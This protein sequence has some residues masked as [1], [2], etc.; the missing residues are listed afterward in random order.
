MESRFDG[1]LYNEGQHIVNLVPDHRTAI[2]SASQASHPTAEMQWF[3]PNLGHAIDILIAPIESRK[4]E[5]FCFTRGHSS[6]SSTVLASHYGFGNSSIPAG[7]IWFRAVGTDRSN[8]AS[9]AE[10]P[11]QSQLS[12]NS[13]SVCNS[14]LNCKR[15]ESTRR[16]IDA[17]SGQR[18][19]YRSRLDQEVK[20]QPNR[21]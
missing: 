9:Q 13:P 18:D 12:S 19:V 2:K 1:D 20:E 5:V 4:M 14:A 6:T 10:M 3:S 16:L 11:A 17:L 15:I 8:A 21:W 7:K